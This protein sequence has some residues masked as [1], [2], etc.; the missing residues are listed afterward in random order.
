MPRLISLLINAACRYCI[1]IQ[2]FNIE[3]IKLYAYTVK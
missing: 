2:K 1:N 3:D